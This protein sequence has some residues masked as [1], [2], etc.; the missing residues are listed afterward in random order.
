L[1]LGP[2]DNVLTA[3]FF[4][5]TVDFNPDPAIINEV[6]SV[7][8]SDAYVSLFN[9]SGVFQTVLTWGG[10]SVDEAHGITTDA[11]HFAVTGCFSGSNVDFD[12]GSGTANKSSNGGLDAFA[13]NFNIT[14]N[15]FIGVNVWGG[16]EGDE[17]WGIAFDVSGYVLV[18][19]EFRGN[20]DFDPGPWTDQRASNGDCD[21]YLI[22]LVL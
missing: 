8:N 6:D 20:V 16:T 12:P 1:T 11:T 7:G 22:N 3:G 5:E 18:T 9:S 19:G 10:S 15:S 21:A 13:S 17:G 2:S 4:Q 14:D